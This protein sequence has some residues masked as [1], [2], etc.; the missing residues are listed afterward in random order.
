VTEE[1]NST[2]SGIET[3]NP[4]QLLRDVVV[5][6]L[7]L[8]MDG[9]RDVVLSPVSILSAVY[10]LITQPDDPGKYFNR[11]LRF[12]RRTDV[13]INLFGASARYRDDNPASSDAY[14]KKLEDLLVGEYQKGG[15]VRNLKDRTDGI[16]GRL[17]Q[18]PDQD[19]S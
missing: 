19:D 15:L 8:A 9:L 13:W 10:G 1:N 2:E 17:G 7:R 4:W 18:R 16:L 12:G 6:Q 3:P 5:F 14:I 11:L